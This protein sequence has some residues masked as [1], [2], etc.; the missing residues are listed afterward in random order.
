MRRDEG[1]ESVLLLLLILLVLIELESKSDEDE[2]KKLLLP[3]KIDEII[4]LLPLM[5][6]EKERLRVVSN[7]LKATVFDDGVV[8]R[9]L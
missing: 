4:L 8:S 9:L 1:D 7:M 3:L 5:G 2:T 6:V